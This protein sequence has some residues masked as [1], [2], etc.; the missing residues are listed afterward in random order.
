MSSFC[1]VLVCIL[2]YYVLHSEQDYVRRERE[3]ERRESALNVLSTSTPIPLPF[4]RADVWGVK[5]AVAF[6]WKSKPL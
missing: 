4:L 6:N 3:R 5:L 2:L 1:H